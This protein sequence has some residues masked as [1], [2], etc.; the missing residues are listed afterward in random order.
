MCWNATVSIQTFCLSCIAIAVAWYKGLYSNIFLYFFFAVAIMQLDEFFLWRNV[1][2]PFWNRVFTV[3]AGCILMVQPLVAIQILRNNAL[4]QNVFYPLYAA[5]ALFTAYRLTNKKAKME[6]EVKNKHLV[7][8]FFEANS[9]NPLL[10]MVWLL[11]YYFLLLT[12]FLL[13]GWY[14]PLSIGILTLLLA[15]YVY[16]DIYP[17]LWCWSLNIVSIYILLY[18]AFTWF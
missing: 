4:L 17:S 1:N 12:P 2:N 7:W 13:E 5:Y 9:L 14:I 8:G 18:A 10:N 16:G 15:Y 11:M 6:T 3:G